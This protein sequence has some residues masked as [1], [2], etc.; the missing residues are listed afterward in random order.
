M[1]ARLADL[2]LKSF[3]QALASTNLQCGWMELFIIKMLECH[4]DI[5]TKTEVMIEIIETDSK[6]EEL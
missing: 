1:V 6:A 5:K 2:G 4:T 3:K